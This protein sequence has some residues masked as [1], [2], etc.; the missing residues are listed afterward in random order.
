MLLQGMAAP[1]KN[2]NCGSHSIITSATYNF[3]QMRYAK[4]LV[5]RSATAEFFMK[6]AG[7]LLCHLLCNI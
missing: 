6:R 4:F 5:D 3:P 7:L 2:T 1:G